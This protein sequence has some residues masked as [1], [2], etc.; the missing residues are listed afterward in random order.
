MKKLTNCF[1]CKLSILIIFLYSVSCSKDAFE[2]DDKESYTVEFRFDPLSNSVKPLSKGLTVYDAQKTLNKTSSAVK[3]STSARIQQGYLYYWSFNAESLKADQ[4]NSPNYS[5]T[6]NGGMEPK[7]YVAGWKHDS[8]AAGKALSLR[9][10]EELIIKM[11]LINVIEVQRLG[12]DVGS[13]ATGAK[14]FNIYY[15]QD[16]VKYITLKEDNQFANVKTASSKNTFEF[17]F[18]DIELNLEKDLYIKITPIAGERGDG[19]MGYNEKTGSFQVDNFRIIGVGTIEN[20]VTIQKFHYHVFDAV[21]RSLIIE[22]AEVYQENN[23]DDFALQLPTGNYMASFI[24]NQSNE[25]LLSSERADA[26]DFFVSNKFSN[27]EASIFGAVYSFE[28]LDNQ[29]Y[30]V[31]LNR[32]YSQV[33]FEFTNTEDLSDV[34]KIVITQ[35]HEPNFFAAFSTTMKNPVLDQ[36]EIVVYPDFT[37]MSKEI[38][39]NQFMGD[40]LGAIPLSYNLVLYDGQDKLLN[41]FKVGATI[42]NNVQLVF[43]GNL[44]I[45]KQSNSKFAIVLNKTWG[46]DIL[47]DF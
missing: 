7:T 8:Y 13:S 35:E 5:I 16:G 38:V 27:S 32:Y 31:S 1:W 24:V 45:E 6:Y 12:L 2:V 14:A 10:L 23:L 4:Y 18:D 22:G 39:F 28:V 11:P 44:P 40:V 37:K 19:G 36:S 33:K 20:N 21:T 41:S 30:T 25:E 42:P 43:R 34:K 46:E 3:Q 17:Y 9:G 47:I 26:D 15:S 29:Q